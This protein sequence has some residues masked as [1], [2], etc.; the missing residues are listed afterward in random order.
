M[1]PV[2]VGRVRPL[3]NGKFEAVIES[4]FGDESRN[5]DTQRDAEQWLHSEGAWGEEDG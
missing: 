2:R 1:S 5:F 3:P 4:D